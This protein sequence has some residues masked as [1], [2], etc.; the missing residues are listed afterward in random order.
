MHRFFR[1]DMQHY[2]EPLTHLVVREF[3]ERPLDT[4]LAVLLLLHLEH[5]LVELLLKGLVG[6]VDAQLLEADM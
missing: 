4:L 6:V 5:E 1:Y 2:C 3:D